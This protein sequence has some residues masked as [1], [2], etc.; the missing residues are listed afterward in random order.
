[1]D[2]SDYK[3]KGGWE[4]DP[5]V[6][7]EKGDMRTIVKQADLDVRTNNMKGRDRA[8]EHREVNSVIDVKQRGRKIVTND[9]MNNSLNAEANVSVSA[10]PCR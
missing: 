7:L 5:K 8:Y 9:R 1:M 10:P 2:G 4:R 6:R 3:R